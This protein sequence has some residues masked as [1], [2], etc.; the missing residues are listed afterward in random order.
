MKLLVTT[1]IQASLETVWHFWTTPNHI[2]QWNNAS[3]DWH[4]PNAENDLKI[5][6]RFKYTMASKDGLL[7]FDLEGKYTNI[8][9]LSAIDYVLDDGRKVEI[10]FEETIDGVLLTESF[11]PEDENPITLQQQGWQAI[12]DNFTKYTNLNHN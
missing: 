2:M 8:D 10:R 6:G 9:Y 4:T 3:E 12:L 11:E 1:T 5:G 7:C